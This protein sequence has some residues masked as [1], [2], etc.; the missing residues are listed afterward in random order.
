MENKKLLDLLRNLFAS[1]DAKP[2]EIGPVEL[3]LTAR[4]LLQHADERAAYPSVG[5]IALE[6]GCSE[7]TVNRAVIVLTKL[8]WLSKETG[9]GRWKPNKYF[10]LLDKLPVPVELRT[11]SVSEDARSVAKTFLG[12]QRKWQPK[13]IFRKGTEQRYSYRFQTLLNKCSGSKFL[14][15]EMLNFALQSPVFTSH[16]HIGPHALRKVWRSL[17]KAYGESE[18]AKK[19]QAA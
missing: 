1:Q 17:E 4:L 9:A 5:T 10:V 12:L 3:A 6:L 11:P 15:I 18:A 14:L 2:Q 8:G 7:A 16:A 19:T 13:R